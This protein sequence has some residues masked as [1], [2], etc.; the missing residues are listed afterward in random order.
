MSVCA[1]RGSRS[2]GAENRQSSFK[3][4]PA[5]LLHS[6][7][8]R[9]PHALMEAGCAKER[10]NVGFMIPA[11]RRNKHQV[12]LITHCQRC[13]SFVPFLPIVILHRCLWDEGQDDD[14]DVDKRNSWVLIISHTFREFNI[15]NGHFPLIGFKLVSRD[16]KQ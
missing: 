16:L 10:H 1:E 15:E 9:L 8:S 6:W 12:R 2:R 7:T 5:I 11:A 3:A 4:G 13:S 14:D